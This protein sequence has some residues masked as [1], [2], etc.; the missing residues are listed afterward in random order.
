MD[1]ALSAASGTSVGD[2]PIQGLWYLGGP[3]SVRGFRTA[4]LGGQ[5]FWRARAEMGRG[6]PAFRLVAFSDAGWVGNRENYRLDPSLLS[7]GGGI[8]TL[9]GLVRLDLAKA[10]RGGSDWRADLYLNGAF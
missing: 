9:D 8:A 1:I 5:S 3:A 6:T 2:V 4:F 10:V 7:V